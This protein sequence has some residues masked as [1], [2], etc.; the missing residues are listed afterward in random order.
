MGCRKR[1]LVNGGS[2]QALCLD[3]GMQTACQGGDGCCPPACNATNDSDCSPRCDNGTVE[4]GETCDPMSS[5][6]A[7]CPWMGCQ[8]RRLEGAAAMCTAR[9]LDDGTQTACARGDGCCPPACNTTNDNDCQPRCGNGVVE[10]KEA[11]D[12]DCPTACPASGCQRRKLQG[13]A[14]QCDARCVDDTVISTCASGD[15]CCPGGCTSVNDGDCMCRCGNGVVEPAC[16]E[17]CEGSNCPTSCPAQGCRRRKLQGSAAQCNARCVDDTVISTCATGDACCPGPCHNNNDRDCA[18]EC[19]NSVVEMGETCDPP[20]ACQTQ[21]DTCVSDR[22]TIKTRKGSV[23]ACTFSC[24]SV[25][26]PCSGTSDG[27]CPSSCTF[28][29]ATC[30]SGQDIDCRRPSP[31]PR[32]CPD[33]EKCCE[34]DPEGGCLI[35]IPFRFGCP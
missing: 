31:M 9:C 26:R 18:P 14:A 8:R 17:T 5:C 34:P 1:R 15:S 25:S 33:G 22:N 16:S 11:C 7:T 28:C 30:G 2:C 20:T 32:P 23:A 12:G 19:G 27:L 21:F 3:D 24:S 35:C 10:G 6:P 13:S 29:G 4:T